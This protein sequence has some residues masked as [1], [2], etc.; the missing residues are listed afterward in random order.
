MKNDTVVASLAT[1]LCLAVPL[2]MLSQEW[3]D[4]NRA[5][6]TP[7]RDV[8]ANY[9]NSCADNAI[10]FTNGD[11][12][13]FPLWYAQEVQGIRTDVRVVNL[14]LLNTDWYI[15]QMRRKAYK[16]DPVPFHLSLIHI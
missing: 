6:R 10:L 13:T 12:D 3:D 4:H 2:Q 14:S 15:D 7:A 5:N 9:L 1:L 8:A 11:N 16:S